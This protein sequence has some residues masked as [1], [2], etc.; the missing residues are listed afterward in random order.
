VVSG[1][2][3][4]ALVG[5]MFVGVSVGQ[6]GAR[7]RADVRAFISPTV[8]FFATVLVMALA[9]L[10][11][12]IQSTTRG[13]VCA[14]VGVVGVG[15]LVR[16]RVQRQLRPHHLGL[17]DAFAYLVAPLCAYLAVVVAGIL[18]VADRDV[19]ATVLGAANIALLAVGMRN[20]W[21]LVIS[22]QR[23]EHAAEH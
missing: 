9:M 18:I 22:L 14:C 8:V 4:A 16:A 1:G 7:S 11:P 15:L 10:A 20:A 5:L 21:D 12:S 3:A 17:E 23:P 13:I 19:G 2:A 6:I